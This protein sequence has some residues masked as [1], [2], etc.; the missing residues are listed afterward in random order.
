MSNKVGVFNQTD[1]KFTG[2]VVNQPFLTSNALTCSRQLIQ[3]LKRSLMRLLTRSLIGSLIGS[4]AR[5][6]LTQSL[7]CEHFFD[8]SLACLLVRLF[9]QLLETQA[10]S[11]V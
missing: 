7:W 9:D 1:R 4:L 10:R 2:Q 6:P 3:S 11:L 5:K 8:R